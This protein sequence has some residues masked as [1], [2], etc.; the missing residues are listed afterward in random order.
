MD[1][2]CGIITV[3]GLSE[4]IIP[5]KVGKTL[6][7]YSIT[8]QNESTTDITAVVSSKGVDKRRIC[9]PNK[10]DGTI[11]IDMRA[12]SHTVAAP[13]QGSAGATSF[14]TYGC[15]ILQGI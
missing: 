9:M 5:A 15:F 1:V 3:A 10:G 11:S 6:F 7:I 2:A 8:V 4:P 13:L 14:P 12:T